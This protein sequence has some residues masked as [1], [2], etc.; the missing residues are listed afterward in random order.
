[1]LVSRECDYDV[2]MPDFVWEYLSEISCCISFSLIHSFS[3]FWH[4]LAFFHK[5]MLLEMCYLIILLWLC[6]SIS[7]NCCEYTVL[8]LLCTMHENLLRCMTIREKDYQSAN[9]N[10]MTIPL[11]KPLSTQISRHSIMHYGHDCDFLPP[12][13]TLL[14]CLLLSCQWWHPHFCREG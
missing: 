5:A 13:Q 2:T 1:M 4:Q 8:R 7:A 6:A 3:G 12:N 10:G 11:Y 9:L 14:Q